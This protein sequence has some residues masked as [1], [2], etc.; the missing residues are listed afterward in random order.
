MSKNDSLPDDV[1]TLKR[2]LRARNAELAQARAETSSA[3]ALIAH[4]RL[5]IEKLKRE[6]FGPRNERRARRSDRVGVEREGF[7]GAPGEDGRA[8]E[9]AGGAGGDPTRVRASTRRK[10]ARHPSR[11]HLPRGGIFVPAPTACTCCG[12][13]R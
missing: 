3:E 4:M 5:T 13:T 8:A 9:R 7:G 1:E 6:M 2:L 11:A 12:S 10:R